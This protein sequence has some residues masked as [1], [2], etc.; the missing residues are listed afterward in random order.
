MY[1]QY[2]LLGLAFRVVLFT[3]TSLVT[4]LRNASLQQLRLQYGMKGPRILE[5]SM[6]KRLYFF[7]SPFLRRTS[8]WAPRSKHSF[9]REMTL[10]LALLGIRLATLVGPL[11]MKMKSALPS[12][13]GRVSEV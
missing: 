5:L 3:L 6:M 1:Y 11:R 9:G 4:R 10:I 2:I 13:V 8:P 12:V 7:H